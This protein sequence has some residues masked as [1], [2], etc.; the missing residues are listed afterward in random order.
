MTDPRRA[1]IYRTVLSAVFADVDRGVMRQVALARGVERLLMLGE[2]DERPA[3]RIQRENAEALREMNELGNNRDSA[4][5]VA[6]RRSTDP[7]TREIL[8]QRFR[9]ARRRRPRRAKTKRAVL[10]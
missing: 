7:H 10:V 9:R 6:S 1:K 2:S 4:K 8:A 3:E 5:K